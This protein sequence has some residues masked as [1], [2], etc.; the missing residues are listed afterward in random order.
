M[1]HVLE[2]TYR[3]DAGVSLLR[4]R[5]DIADFVDQVLSAGWEYTAAAVY[6]VVEGS[7]ADPDHE[8]IIGADPRTGMGALRYAGDGDWFSRGERTG[9]EEVVF[10]YFGVRHDFPADAEVPL[11]TVREA[12]WEL[13]TTGGRRPGCV[14][15]QEDRG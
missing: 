15:W 10:T 5:E 6:A 8:L 3:H 2:A 1:G 12:M 13:L 14:T 4:T 7:E 11:D 9:P